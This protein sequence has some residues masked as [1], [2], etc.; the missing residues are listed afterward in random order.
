MRDDWNELLSNFT[1]SKMAGISRRNEFVKEILI[2]YLTRDRG[3]ITR[4]LGEEYGCL[5]GIDLIIDFLK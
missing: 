5:P 2:L 4:K 3:N 1:K